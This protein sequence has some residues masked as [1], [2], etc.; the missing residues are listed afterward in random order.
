MTGTN[1][2]EN[3]SGSSLTYIIRARFVALNVA[4]FFFFG[5]RSV[6]DALRDMT[7]HDD[8]DDDIRV[9]ERRADDVYAN[10]N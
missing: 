8:D 1:V 2:S 9:A 5:N 6:H 10:G 7:R 4:E 3:T